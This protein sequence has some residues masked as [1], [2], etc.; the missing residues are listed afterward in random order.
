M[1][2]FMHGAFP[3]P[4]AAG[5]ALVRWAGAMSCR[6][7]AVAL[8]LV[9]VAA[10]AAEDRHGYCSS[11]LCIVE[12]GAFSEVSGVAGTQVLGYG[13]TG[14]RR[15]Q[16]FVLAGAN[17]RFRP[18][19]SGRFL[20]KL[21]LEGGI[22]AIVPATGVGGDAFFGAAASLRVGLVFSHFSF[23]LGVQ[24]RLDATPSPFSILPSLTLAYRPGAF[25]VRAAL[26]DEPQGPIGRVL[27]EWR[28]FSAG[29]VLPL[30]AEI[31]GR[32]AVSRRLA[33][34]ARVY[35]Y[36]VPPAFGVGT[37]VGLAFGEGLMWHE[38]DTE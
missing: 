15:A 8:L 36:S 1:P 35:G 30:G 2:I 23:A 17:G 28:N 3:P 26:F 24:A 22:V 9:A 37:L 29:L 20:D 13:Y 32:F 11:E 10:D 7:L 4:F 31:A 21:L 38:R 18:E 12:P 25:G 27:L 19:R 5:R 34:D 33:I 16:L 6:V 14:G